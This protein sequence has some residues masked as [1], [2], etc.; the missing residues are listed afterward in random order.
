[1]QVRELRS[2]LHVIEADCAKADGEVRRA[3]RAV[4]DAEATARHAREESDALRSKL[5]EVEAA[6]ESQAAAAHSEEAV[7]GMEA[8]LG[9]MAAL[10]QKKEAELEATKRI[11]QAECDERVRLL[12]LVN[13]LQA[14]ATQTQQH[15]VVPL[16]ALNKLPG[17]TGGSLR[18]GGDPDVPQQPWPPRMAA[19]P[20]VAA[21]DRRVGSRGA[22]RGRG[23]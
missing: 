5:A 17:S 9:R 13:Q 14:D 15:M 8:A 1:V 21:A 16:S 23:R 19:H 11:V 2:K 20:A 10:L 6:A 4:A 3:A 18:A 7:S 12:A 22:S